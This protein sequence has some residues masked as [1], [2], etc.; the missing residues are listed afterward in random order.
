M[1]N[2]QIDPESK[3]WWKWALWVAVFSTGWYLLMR[4]LGMF[5]F[6]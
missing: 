1:S 5:G 3:P 2:G 4:L 6:D